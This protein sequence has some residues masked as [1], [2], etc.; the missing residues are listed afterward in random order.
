MFS[1]WLTFSVD[2]SIFWGR[3]YEPRRT[4]RL[5]TLTETLIKPD[6]TKTEFNN[7]F[8]IPCFK[9]KNRNRQTH[10][11]TDHSLTLLL[12]IMHEN[13]HISQLPAGS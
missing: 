2:F 8:I 3:S 13:L 6:I 1:L 5:I 11:R 9:E 7:C 12:E 4:P 10:R